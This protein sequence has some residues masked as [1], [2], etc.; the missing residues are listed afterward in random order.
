MFK[1]VFQL[2]SKDI[3]KMQQHLESIDPYF[4][5]S[6]AEKVSSNESMSIYESIMSKKYQFKD[7]WGVFVNIKN[8]NI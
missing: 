6:E 5:Y 7:L 2:I 8:D 3:K 1:G 4:A